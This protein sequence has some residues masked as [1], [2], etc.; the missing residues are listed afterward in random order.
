MPVSRYRAAVPAAALT[1]AAALAGCAG[2]PQRPADTPRRTGVAAAPAPERRAPEL[3]ATLPGLGPATLARI[4]AGTGQVLVV[5]GRGRDA[6]TATAVLHVRTPLGW[7]AGRAWPARNARDGWTDEHYADDMRSPIGVFA[8]TD[9]GGRSENPGTR[10][11]YDRSPRF[12]AEGD[13]FDGEPL[14]GS[15]DYVVAINY[16]REAGVSPL[17]R[18]RPLGEERGG[19]IWL[20]VDHGG[21][22]HGCVALSERD[23]RDLLRRLDPARYPVIVMGDAASLAR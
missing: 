2:H 13:G 14:D 16:N 4:P 11:P 23:L 12:V 18:G 1:L 5:T 9:A 22:T 8:L 6:A 19:G 3:P 15:F 7:S 20:H 10:L 17:D 21:P